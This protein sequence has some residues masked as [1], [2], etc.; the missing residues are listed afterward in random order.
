MYSNDNRHIPK[1]SLPFGPPQD[2]RLRGRKVDREIDTNGSM[3]R[4]WKWKHAKDME[5]E[6]RTDT[7][8]RK[9]ALPQRNLRARL[10]IRTTDGMHYQP[11]RCL[12]C[13][14][15]FD[16]LGKG[17]RLRIV[18]KLRRMDDTYTVNEEF[19]KLNRRVLV[20]LF[21]RSRWSDILRAEK[22]EKSELAE[23]AVGPQFELRSTITHHVESLV[24]AASGWRVAR[25]GPCV[26]TIEEPRS[27]VFRHHAWARHFRYLGRTRA[28]EGAAAHSPLPRSPRVAR[29]TN[30]RT[31]EKPL[32]AVLRSITK[33]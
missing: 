15:S 7:Q 12:I 33:Q 27:I 24:P 9:E 8:L 4:T 6:G 26:E 11:K 20:I 18:R 23:N 5:M 10:E 16:A 2:A 25:G 19:G 30:K 29:L 1:K 28:E 31:Q 17:K 3:R 22:L 32:V 14:A 13:A 21:A